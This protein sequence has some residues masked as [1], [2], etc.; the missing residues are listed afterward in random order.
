M[1][2]IVVSTLTIDLRRRMFRT[3]SKSQADG[4]KPEQPLQDPRMAA[5]LRST[6]SAHSD[7]PGV[8]THG[9]HGLR[10]RAVAFTHGFVGQ[11]GAPGGVSEGRLRG[12]LSAG[13]HGIP[14]ISDRVLG[15]RQILNKQRRGNSTAQVDPAE[16]A[17]AVQFIL[18]TH[19]AGADAHADRFAKPEAC[20]LWRCPKSLAECS[21]HAR[22]NR[23]TPTLSAQ[24][25]R[26][27]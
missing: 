10:Y 11:Y 8:G 16:L 4:P 25:T 7:D 1:R 3:L 27:S 18:G 14:L 19:R 22:R 12:A 21:C 17:S 23:S 15:I 20:K 5:F 13:Q 6:T 2:V 24:T 9:I 26:S